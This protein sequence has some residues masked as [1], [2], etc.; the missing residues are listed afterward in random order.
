MV[1]TLFVDV[2][3]CRPWTPDLSLLHK[4]DYSVTYEQSEINIPDYAR[5]VNTRGYT[6]L[7]NTSL[8]PRNNRS[9]PR[10]LY[11]KAGKPATESTSAQGPSFSQE[12][13]I[14][15]QKV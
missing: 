8:H 7:R 12:V 10:N 11:I 13:L 14:P 15:E 2:P 3:R 5:T 4:V 9:H 1:H 6:R